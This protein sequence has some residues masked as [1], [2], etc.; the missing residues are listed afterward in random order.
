[1]EIKSNR[2]LFLYLEMRKL[3]Y[4]ILVLIIFA[5]SGNIQAPTST[6]LDKAFEK[7]SISI[8]LPEFNNGT[9][10]NYTDS[11]EYLCVYLLN[12][13]TIHIYDS[14]FNLKKTNKYKGRN[15][16]IFIYVDSNYSHS[17]FDTSPIVGFIENR[18]SIKNKKIVFLIDSSVDYELYYDLLLNLG[19]C[20]ES[21]KKMIHIIDINNTVLQVR[22]P[23]LYRGN[24]TCG[25]ISYRN[26]L[27]I[28]INNKN[29]LTI[30]K[31]FNKKFSEI[32]DITRKFYSNINNDEWLPRL[33]EVTREICKENIAILKENKEIAK[34]E[35]QK[36]IISEEIEIWQK[37]LNYVNQ[38]GSYRKINRASQILIQLQSGNSSK[39]YIR[40]LD[41]IN[42]GLLSLRDS[43]SINKFQK[44][45]T[46]LNQNDSIEKLRKESIEEVYPVVVNPINYYERPLLPP[47]PKIK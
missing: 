20:V 22:L 23:Y 21:E 2:N 5:C 38:I 16:G 24:V 9:N 29:Q 4:F 46:E 47:P 39:P 31:D 10:I 25:M 1:M 3:L 43:L 18:N 11:I 32:P 6:F 44:L 14:T 30:K 26:M 37:K 13:S 41:S 33:D 8:N 15:F 35:I 42:S 19:K 40:I 12:D 27:E 28:W 7:D 17:Y 36:K 34:R 45:Y